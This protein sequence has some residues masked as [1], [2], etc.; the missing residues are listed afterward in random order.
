MQ[1]TDEGIITMNTQ[2]WI[3]RVVTRPYAAPA[4]TLPAALRTDPLG[5]AARGALVLALALGSLGAGA[6]AASGAASAGHAS[7]HHPAEGVHLATGAAL[8]PPSHAS[9]SGWM[10]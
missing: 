3:T 8:A 5:H 10:Y 6:I 1:V 7:A 2:R 9:L 4:G